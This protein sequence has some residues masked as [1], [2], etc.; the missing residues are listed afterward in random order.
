MGEAE[1]I[2]RTRGSPV[3]QRT[4]VRDL[5]RLGVAP[6]MVLLVHS[7]L[8]AIGW[9]CGGAEAVIYAMEEVLRPFGTLV[10]PT[11]SGQ[12]SDPSGWNHPPVPPSWWE[13]IRRTMP[14]FDP[15][16]TPTRGMGAIP[17][18][19]RKQPDVVRSVHPQVSFAAWGE[20]SL[21]ILQSHPLDYG[22]GESSPL[23]RVYEL[24]GW[25]LLLGVGH[26][27]D[28]SLHLAEYRAWFRGKRIVANAAPV[29]IGGHRRWKR[30]KDINLDSSDFGLLGRHF[31]QD[32]GASIRSGTVG[33]ARCQLF[34]QR[35]AVDYAVKWLERNRR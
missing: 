28:T 24:D 10:M 3:T 6:G 17:E 22:L 31:L 27:R 8:S 1:V 7:S 14:P 33:A 13:T 25:V 15:D 12:L 20:Q 32:W 23:A 5:K 21:P 4:L 18:C 2:A 34:P 19:F 11:H 30:F 26:D 9:V 29:R 35:L 16:L